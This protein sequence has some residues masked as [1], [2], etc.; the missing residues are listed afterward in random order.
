MNNNQRMLQ[1]QFN[2]Q[3]KERHDFV[4]ATDAEKKKNAKNGEGD[5][6]E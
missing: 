3:S 2:K 5:N 1:Q 6:E 4:H